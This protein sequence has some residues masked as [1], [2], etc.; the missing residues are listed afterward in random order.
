M[1]MQSTAGQGEMSMEGFAGLLTA[2]LETAIMIVAMVLLARFILS[3]LNH[4]FDPAFGGKEKPATRLAVFSLRNATLKM[5]LP[6]TV[7]LIGLE[8]LTRQA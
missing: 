1:V 7:I 5:T 6:F 4:H 2:S 3:R 8:H